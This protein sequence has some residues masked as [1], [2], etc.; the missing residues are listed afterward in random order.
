LARHADFDGSL[1]LTHISRSSNG[2]RLAGARVGIAGGSRGIGR[3]IAAAVL[4]EGGIPIIGS[5]GDSERIA[6]R[7]ALGEGAEEQRLD[8]ASE[9]SVCRFMERA[10]PDH[11]V[12]SLGGPE[13]PAMPYE[14][15]PTESLRAH[16]EIYFWPACLL[17]R[18]FLRTAR[19]TNRSSLL[20]V[21]G[22]LS[23]RPLPGKSAF[24]AAQWAIEG[25]ALALVAEAAPIRV[26][27][28]VPGLVRTPRWNA[29]GPDGGEDF[30]REA[31]SEL[32]G[33]EVPT[34]DVV[35]SAGAELLSNRYM[36]GA[37]MVVD[38]GWTL[39]AANL[40]R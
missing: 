4:V 24:T 28:L 17:A 11:L 9:D 39:G 18:T 20:L 40:R 25:L 35:A 15:M 29:L 30:Y 10:N 8:A 2:G 3:A 7:E 12:V 36:T 37:S 22:G 32:P 14:Q 38:G 21:T 33:L 27:V 13:E 31:A 34:P 1:V 5:R 6:A 19:R 26:N 23:R 16:F